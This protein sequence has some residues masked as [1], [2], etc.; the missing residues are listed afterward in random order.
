MNSRYIISLAMWQIGPAEVRAGPL[1][2]N[3]DLPGYATC[4]ALRLVNE[5]AL[6]V[7]GNPIGRIECRQLNEV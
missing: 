4:S 6:T 3:I 7:E 5:S 1:I 2:V